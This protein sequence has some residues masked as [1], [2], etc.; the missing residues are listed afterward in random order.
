[1]DKISIW[2]GNTPLRKWQLEHVTKKYYSEYFSKLRN[3][4]VLEI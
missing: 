4:I 1:M 3:K 2:S